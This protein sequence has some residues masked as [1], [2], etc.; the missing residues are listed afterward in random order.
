ME[1][2][3]YGALRDAQVSE[4]H[5]RMLKEV[6]IS[7]NICKSLIRLSKTSGDDDIIVQF[8]VLRSIAVEIDNISC[9]VAILPLSNDLV[10][11]VF[12]FHKLFRDSICHIEQRVQHTSK[13][14]RQPAKNLM[15]ET[16]SLADGLA[17]S[18][19]GGRSWHSNSST[20]M[21]LHF[22]LGVSVSVGM[23]DNYLIC[24]TENG[25]VS[26]QINI[27]NIQLLDSALVAAVKNI[28]V[29]PDLKTR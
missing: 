5:L 11:S 22:G 2:K 6:S 1:E 10:A 29:P 27:E 20:I 3:F 8:G 16:M 14:P 9:L 21:N 23:L 26:Q 13:V 19:D 4:I 15:W 7:L 18:T 12:P 25:A 28:R 24:L 17:T